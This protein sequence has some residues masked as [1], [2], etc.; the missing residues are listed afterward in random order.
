MPGT[1]CM[2]AGKNAE[3]RTSRCAEKIPPQRSVFSVQMDGRAGGKMLDVGLFCRPT[4]KCN[5]PTSF[6]SPN[7]LVE[8][9]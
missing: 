6:Q 3:L 5:P 2:E 7:D 8:Y 9:H 1:P 4:P